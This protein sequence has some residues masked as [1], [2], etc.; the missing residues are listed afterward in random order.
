MVKLRRR[1]FLPDISWFDFLALL[2]R[3]SLILIPNHAYFK[4]EDTI[5]P[6]DD[7]DTC[8][9]NE[10]EYDALNEETFGGLEGTSNN[11]DWEQ[12]HEQFAEIAESSKYSEK[13]GEYYTF[14]F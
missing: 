8:L 10:E 5:L 1:F 7:E 4:D 2:R 11:D 6:P 13:L 3:D 14:L 9:E 12:Q